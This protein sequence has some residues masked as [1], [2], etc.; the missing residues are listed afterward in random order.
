[1]SCRLELAPPRSGSAYARLSYRDVLDLCIVGVATCVSLDADQR[2]TSVR[3]GLGSVAARP[4]RAPRTEAFLDGKVLT[5]DVIAEAGRVSSG[6]A[7]PITDQRASAEYRRLMVPVL[8]RRAA[9]RSEQ[10]LTLRPRQH[11]LRRGEPLGEALGQITWRDELGN[12]DR[13]ARTGERTR[14][15]ATAEMRC[16]RTCR[17]DHD[18][19]ACLERGALARETDGGVTKRAEIARTN[20]T[21]D[22]RGRSFD[23]R[24]MLNAECSMLN[25]CP[26]RFGH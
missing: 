4:V 17:D 18:A 1:M 11:P 24:S 12:D 25:E 26:N 14:L 13:R 22:T 19:I 3:F 7:N 20:Q 10:G 8:T 15:D 9:R 16:G 23:Q 21:G 2:V 5:D 6:D